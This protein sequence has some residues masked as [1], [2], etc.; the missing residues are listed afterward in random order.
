MPLSKTMLYTT[1]ITITTIVVF[2]SISTFIPSNYIPIANVVYIIAFMF[3]VMAIP[4]IMM[5]KKSVEIRGTI[6]LKASPQEVMNLTLKDSELEKELR[7]QIMAM[8]MMTFIPLILWFILAGFISSALS[9]IT[10]SSNVLHRFVGYIIFYSVLLGIIRIVT[11]FITPKKMIM[12]INSY[13]IRSDGIKAS[14]LVL[15]FPIDINRYQVNINMKRNFF[16]IIDKS[17]RYAYRFYVS[18]INK[19]KNVLEKY[20]GIKSGT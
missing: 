16:E 15:T 3:I 12:P 4:R 8:I 9:P 10:T 14:G 11:Y 18:D 6:L 5:R 17:T 19:A 20:G 1:G 7:P 2:S 13:E